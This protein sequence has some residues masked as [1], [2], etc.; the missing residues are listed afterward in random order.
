MS[1]PLSP[2]QLDQLCRDLWGEYDAAAIAQLAPLAYESCYLPKFVKAPDSLAELVPAFPGFAEATLEIKPGSIIYGFYLPSTINPAASPIVQ[3]PSW[4]V[5]I[6][7]VSQDSKGNSLNHKWWDEPI[8]AA[9]LSNLKI[10]SLSYFAN[11]VGSFPHLLPGPYPVVGS[12][13]FQFE[14][15]N[16]SAAQQRIEL[17]LGVLEAVK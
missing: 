2:L 17:V 14:F 3:D 13:M 15:W 10:C 6:T 11:Q 4:N 8:P 7:D 12:G 5:Q 1:L 16:K 9:F